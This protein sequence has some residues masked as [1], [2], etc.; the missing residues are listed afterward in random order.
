MPF[1]FEEMED[2]AWQLLSS[3]KRPSRYA[4]GEWGACGGS[5][6][7]EEKVSLCLAF[8]DVYE[9]G[10][11]YLGFQILYNLASGLPGVRVERSYCPWPDAEAFM[12]ERGMPLSSLESGRSLNTFDLV[13]FTLQYELTST[14]I[15]TM[16]DMGGIPIRASERGGEDPIVVAGGPGA[17][18]PEPLSPFFDAFCAGDGELLLPELLAVLKDD[19]AR[20]RGE[21]LEI[22]SSMEGFYVPMLH[23]KGR[24]RRRVLMDLDGG[25]CPSG[26]IVPSCEIIHDRVGVEVFRGC[27]RGCRFCQAGMVSRPVRERSPEK[28]A[29]IARDLLESTGYDEVGLVSLASCDYSG[30]EKVVDLLWPELSGKDIR[31]S[32]PSLRMDGFSVELADRLE[33]FGRGGLTFAPEAGT[34]RLR[35]VINKGISGD[36]ID[37]T[38]HEV[39]S[40]G[41][42]KVKLYFMMGLP[43]EKAEDIEAIIDLSVSARTIGKKFG[44]RPRISVSV[45]GFVPKPHTPFQWEPQASMEELAEKGGYLKKMAKRAGISLNYHEPSQTFLEGVIARGDSRIAEAIER[46]WRKGARFDGWSECFSHAIWME[47]FEDSGIDPLEYSVRPRGAE[48][49]LPWEIIDAGVSRSFLWSEKERALSG[50]LT[51]D[52]RDGN[53]RQCGWQAACPALER[54]DA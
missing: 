21:V 18:A 6:D 52:C 43:T 17:L 5:V 26:M 27:T 19:P 49:V 50:E 34:Q 7:G 46:A 40:R 38:F 12:R 29:A 42:E 45:A 41:W 3:V 33:S 51:P 15:L 1:L 28:V 22:L 8:P 9:V 14:N 54:R 36:D 39:F 2:Q 13:G 48:E 53:C 25:F 47:A 31:L 37:R 23:G 30:I 24:V 44:K 32:L 4:G 11:S 35:D 20:D 16:L 10:M